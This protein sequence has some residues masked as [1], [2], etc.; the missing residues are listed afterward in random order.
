MCASTEPQ[1]LQTLAE[2][3]RNEKDQTLRKDPGCRLSP[4]DIHVLRA[5]GRDLVRATVSL[6]V[7]SLICPALRP[8]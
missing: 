3:N 2:G 8:I 6:G 5:D 7:V 4:S 1:K